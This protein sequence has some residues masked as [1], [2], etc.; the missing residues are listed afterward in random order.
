MPIFVSVW[1][2]WSVISSSR[3]IKQFSIIVET[4]IR[5][6][7]N[8]SYQAVPPAPA[9]G[10]SKLPNQIKISWFP[11][12]P[13]G[14]ELRRWYL[15]KAYNSLAIIHNMYVIAMRKDRCILLLLDRLKHFNF[16]LHS[17]LYHEYSIMSGITFNVV[18]FSRL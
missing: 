4:H 5:F 8:L 9:L 18:S 2:Y 6:S 7:A 13:L 10:C 1:K 16:F 14:M 15:E 3:T 11:D 17:K 12:L